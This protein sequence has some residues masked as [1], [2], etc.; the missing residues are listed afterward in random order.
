MLGK[1][2]RLGGTRPTSVPDGL[3]VYAI[4]DIHGRADLL[5]ILHRRIERESAKGAK[6]VIYLGDYVDRG[7]ESRAVIDLLRTAP[8]NGCR[9]VFLRGNH[10]QAMLDFLQEWRVALGSLNFGGG[11]ALKSYRIQ[12]TVCVDRKSPPP[13]ARPML[14]HEASRHLGLLL[15]T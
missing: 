10:E 1:W 14:G 3:T 12:G 15:G 11:G 5:E 8:P 13:I 7:P 6:L 4:G 9:H 2:L